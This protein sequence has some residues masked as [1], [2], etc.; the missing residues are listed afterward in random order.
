MNVNDE[1]L[2]I[3][4]NCVGVFFLFLIP[5]GRF[6]RGADIDISVKVNGSF[7]RDTY[8]SINNFQTTKLI[9]LLKGS[10][11]ATL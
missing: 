6:E 5:R 9:S 8:I 11:T 2:F 10:K 1:R 4:Q 7:C 3:V